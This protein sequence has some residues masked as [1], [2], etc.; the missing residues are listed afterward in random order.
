M[1]EKII[2][3]S[4]KNKLIVL[5]FTL[6]V[7]G[8]GLFSVFQI[9][10]GAVPDVTN[11]QVQ[12]ITT[13]RN[14]S[15][16][17]IEQ[18]ITYPVEIEM[19]NLPGVKEIRSISKFG[20]SVVTIVFDENLG[21]YLPRQLIA[22]KIKT[23]SEKI[24]QGF[25]TPEMGPITTGLGEIYQYTLEVK[26]EFK[27]NYSVT[28]L[29]TI[30]DWVVKRQLSGIKGVVEINTWGG[31]LKQY[32]IAISPSRLKA[33][34]ITTA[35][36]F[37]ALEKN[38]SIAGGAYIEK[39]NQS[40]FIRGE[41]KVNSLEDIG[42]IVVAN[43]NGLPV[44]I[45]NV[46]QVRF[47]HANRFGAITGNGEGEKVLGQVMMLKGGNSK[48]VIDDVKNRVAEIQKTLPDGV[49]INGF[50]ER[51][52][53]VGKTTFT[54]AENLILGCL[55]VIFV[56]I[57]L[58]GNWRSGLVVASVI[59]LCLLFAISFMN[60]FGIDANLMSLGAIDFGIIIDGAVIIVEFIA[61]QIA[62][63]SAHLVNLSKE[64]R[65]LEIDQITYKSASKMMNSAIFG[66]LI[67]LIVFIPILSLS[68][69][70]GKMFKPMAMTFSFALLGAMIFCFTYVPVVSSLFLK[71]KAENP[72]SLSSKLIH[73]LNSWYLPIITWAVS[74]TKKVMYGAL[75]LLL[76]AVGLF[77]TMGGEFIP[78]LDEGDFVIQPVLKTGTSLTKTIA[79]TTKIEKIILNNF[80][81]VT[82]VVSRIGAAEVPTD[83]M[84]MEESDII[85]KLKPKS[86]W[87]SASTK[88]ELADKIKA[89]LEKQIPNMEIEFTQPIE[90]RFNELISGTRSDV[91]VK[92]FG[93][94]LNILAQKAHEI[95]NAIA[96]V[97]G[98]SDIII[99]KTEG[100]PQMSVVYDRSKIARYG[101]NIA[102]LNEMIALGFAGKTV[103]NV[104]EGEKRFDMVIRLD[105]ANRHDVE[106]LRNLYV[107]TPNGEQIPL[108]E[109]ASIEY[110]E[111]PA[112]ISRD[113][114]NRR[115][116]VGINVRN[117]D[118]QS[119]VTDIQKIVDNQVKLPAGYY[120]KYGGQF[121]N[122]QSAKARLMI[123]VPI[124]LFLIFILL[125]F[126]FGS[127][128]EA[129]MVYSA[130]PLSAVGGVLF[131]WIRDLPF[132]ISAGVGFIALFG[133]AV[134]N[135]IVLIEH[136]KE[137]KHQGMKDIDALILKG[138]TDRLRPVLLTASAAALGF[139]P[140]AISSSAGAEVQRPLATVVIGGLF[141][142]TILTMIVL[143][144]L[145]KV[146]DSQ[147]FKKAKFKKHQ[148]ATYIILLL[149][150]SSWAFSQNTNPELD[151]LLS[152]AIQNNKGIKAAQLQVDKTK[153]N[154]KTANTFDK[155]NIYYSY[156]QNNLALNNEPLRVFGVQQRFSFPTVY[157]AQKK[158]FS[159]E[160]ER[161]KANFDIQKNKLSLAVSKSYQHIVYLQHQEKLYQYLDSL[162]QNFSKASDRRFE[163]GETNYLEKIT[164]QA[165]FRQIRTKLSQIENDKKAQYELLQSLLQ[166]DEIIT[167]NS[168]SITPLNTFTDATSELF[169]TAYLE[170]VTENYKNQ[171]KL[172]K[173]H[174]LPDI[175]LD[176]FQGKNNGLSQSLYGFQ[177]GLAV[178]IL[179]SGQVAKS[180]VAQ[181]ELQSWEQ[182]KQNEEVK[183]EKYINQ[184]KNE[185]AKH[186]EAINYYN[187]YGKKLSDEIIK[188]GNNS[189]KHG[190][191]DF[192]QYI[193]SLE[194][195]TTIQVD[196]LDTILQF[197]QTQLDL[198]YLNF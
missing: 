77:A 194:N 65:Q 101:L 176:Y 148:S 171:I 185:L 100:L 71:P 79:I 161:E 78:T 195:A 105:Q 142:A 132:S 76:L 188:V 164:A 137:L 72:N 179:F 81:E 18:F 193:Q 174:W 189:Y 157:G 3:F 32:E 34:N 139:L 89:A 183:I 120:V 5:L 158:V 60:I 50:L 15:T 141:T 61:F 93:E 182:Q 31:F 169:Y 41:G 80:P 106:D 47:G 126:A 153:A 180:K 104:F 110:T 165:K 17:D 82:Q 16:Q 22:E 43:A 27:N 177:V 197:N 173:Q 140:M 196:Y 131:L 146:F 119:V 91:A 96:K 57:L 170:S 135:G 11:N 14:L 108:S 24:P 84:S 162:Y 54:V 40:Y 181:L 150:S 123:A 113:N 64:E 112:K 59:P 2:A 147:T 151:S 26:P 33:M 39:V 103:G 38:N 130:I 28:D 136:F 154:I 156:D 109:L 159:S 21:T 187:L 160:Y 19:A 92:V 163:L 45:K 186:Q 117:R 133:I 30:Q 191:I 127:V 152:K 66:Q 74:N 167:I 52:E 7:F 13:S 129:L 88:D 53:L 29:R 25:G 97:E 4:L 44:Y 37:T 125:Y 175:N 102:D 99:E 68:G 172:Q 190:E 134:L 178:P 8:F 94:D 75:G 115:I 51:S 70:E 192:F 128:K 67:I 168:N 198:Q 56:V 58:L 46:A 10:I 6:G 124:A 155:T 86:E 143:P 49:Y 107:P 114:T 12:V 166:N 42:N 111:G 138:T 85:V 48:Q 98:A 149:L 83:P 69:I 20:L 55:I 145:Y 118:L 36:V 95:K 62:S 87:T 184:K 23:A 35:D 144:I 73:K 90:M 9:S 121:E 116:V 122:L 1:L 63:K